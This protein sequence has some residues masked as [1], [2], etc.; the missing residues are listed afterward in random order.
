MCNLP[1][2]SA[3]PIPSHVRIRLY[4][5]SA[6]FT[7]DARRG[8]DVPLVRSPPQ[9]RH[10][11]SSLDPALRARSA[12]LY[13]QP[14]PRTGTAATRECIRHIARRIPH[15]QPTRPTRIS[16]PARRSPLSLSLSLS[17][18][19]AERPRPLYTHTTQ[20]EAPSRPHS[21]SQYTRERGTRAAPRPALLTLL[22]PIPRAALATAAWHFPRSPPPLLPTHYHARISQRSARPGS[23]HQQR[24]PAAAPACSSSPTLH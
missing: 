18:R 3:L 16:G 21:K 7:R 10:P 23:C 6:P 20:V 11:P 14:P 1:I 15:A 9:K 24:L 8:I 4:R 5:I 17:L 13:L 19:K 12:T 2:P 22:K